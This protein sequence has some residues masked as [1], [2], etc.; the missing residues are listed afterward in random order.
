MTLVYQAPEPHRCTPHVF[1]RSKEQPLGSIWRCDDCGRFWL[2]RN[3]CWDEFRRWVPVRWYHRAAHK[4]ITRWQEKRALAAAR[5]RG[6]VIPAPNAAQTLT[7]KTVQESIYAK[8]R[9][10]VPGEGYVPIDPKGRIPVEEKK[11]AMM[12]QMAQA[13]EKVEADS[14]KL[15]LTRAG[16]DGEK[17]WREA[18]DRTPTRF[19]VTVKIY[20]SPFDD[21]PHSTFVWEGTRF[22]IGELAGEF[23]DGIDNPLLHMEID[24]VEALDE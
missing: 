14:R 12:E 11:A 22:Q 21:E 20:G 6:T 1:N 3:G 15:Y 10:T 18:D 23:A 24:T 13:K 5:Q 16:A 8:L 17:A 7:N 19:R 9:D 4:R 2:R